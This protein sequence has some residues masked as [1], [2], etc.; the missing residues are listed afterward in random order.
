M[1]FLKKILKSRAELDE[2]LSRI[3]PNTMQK[4]DLIDGWSVKDLIAHIGWYERE[5]QLVLKQKV[6]KGSNLWGLELTERNDVIFTENK[7]RSLA[8][9]VNSEEETYR[10][11]LSLLEDMPESDLNDPAAFVEMPSDWQP[12]SVIASN[13]Y[14]HY[15]DHTKDLKRI[16]ENIGNKSW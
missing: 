10:E 9:V 12:W 1:D 4:Q 6:F 16:A 15:M 13:T 8:E 7:D 14:E 5:M 2:A 11:L 3:Q